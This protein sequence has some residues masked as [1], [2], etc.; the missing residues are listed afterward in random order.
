MKKNKKNEFDWI[1]SIENEISAEDQLKHKEYAKKVVKNKKIKKILFWTFTSSALTA[2]IG[3]A[4]G[5]ALN[6]PAK[7]LIYWYD[8]IKKYSFSDIKEGKHPDIQI[9]INKNNSLAFTPEGL[10]KEIVNNKNEE[11][12]RLIFG[13]TNNE[14]Y[15]KF[16]LKNKQKNWEMEF[17][18]FVI[19]T[20]SKDI[21]YVDLV[22]KEKGNTPIDF[23]IK[24]FPI[25][26][27]K[28]TEK[29]STENPQIK[30]KQ[31]QLGKVYIEEIKKK[32]AYNFYTQI[33]LKDNF[34]VSTIKSYKEEFKKYIDQYNKKIETANEF[35]QNLDL[36]WNFSEPFQSTNNL[37]QMKIASNITTDTFNFFAPI[38]FTKKIELINF[39]EENWK[40]T[41]R[42]KFDAKIL[43]LSTH[44]E[45]LGSKKVQ[46]GIYIEIKTDDQEI[47]INAPLSFR[48]IPK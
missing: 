14:A 38:V 20:I 29:Y 6:K 42:L 24:N 18:N 11:N 25:K 41:S 15:A 9:E 31:T 10:I 1:D 35:Y 21:L 12:V 32:I 37:G 36:S 27:S 28:K 43:T 26:T 3:A 34:P 13:D 47:E 16:N 45:K 22:L 7:A 23:V 30:E 48:K 5:I 4:I 19:D 46:Y 33:D 44:T 2:I 17:E 40:Q 39:D 8:R